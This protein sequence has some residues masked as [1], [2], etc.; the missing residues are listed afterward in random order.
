MTET[1]PPE[2][3][4]DPLWFKDAMWLEI[5]MRNLLEVLGGHQ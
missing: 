3:P 1:P 5:P 2:L 4:D